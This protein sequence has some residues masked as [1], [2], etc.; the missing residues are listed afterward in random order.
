M[1]GAW[2]CRRGRPVSCSGL[3][4]GPEGLPPGSELGEAKAVVGLLRGS[5]LPMPVAQGGGGVV[6]LPPGR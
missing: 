2:V 5:A 6:G 1:E 4:G 3:G